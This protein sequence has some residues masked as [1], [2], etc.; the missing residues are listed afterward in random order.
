MSKKRGKSKRKAPPSKGDTRK[1]TSFR[2]GRRTFI[3]TGVAALLGIPAYFGVSA[4]ID[5]Q[6]VLHDLSIIGDGHPV[7]VQIHDP[8]CPRCRTLLSSVE[9]V[10]KDYPSLKFRIANIK[11]GSGSVFA[12]RH[13]VSNVT[14]LLFNPNGEKIDTGVGFQDKDE[15]RE[16]IAQHIKNTG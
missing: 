11:T 16:F 14:L 13:G 8:Q 12:G 15:V 5:Q 2:P 7:L 3:S 6:A 1:K 10:L 4:Y 9:S